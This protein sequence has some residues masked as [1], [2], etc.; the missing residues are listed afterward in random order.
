MVEKI[1]EYLKSGDKEI[2]ELGVLLAKE[3]LTSED[4]KNMDFLEVY[5]RM[6]I[7]LAVDQRIFL[8]ERGWKNNEL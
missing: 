5:Q 7:C 1:F 2:K 8:E 6:D 4:L 3:H